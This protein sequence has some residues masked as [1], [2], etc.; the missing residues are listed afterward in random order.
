MW[1][2]LK[3]YLYKN[4]PWSDILAATD[5]AISSMC[6]TKLQATPIQLVFVHGMIFENPF[7]VYLEAVVIRKQQ[8]IN[9]KNQN[10]NINHKPHYYTVRE[11]VLVCDQ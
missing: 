6:H 4:D 7:I 10:E 2:T 1:L 3:N 9:K 5:L 11:K 8:P